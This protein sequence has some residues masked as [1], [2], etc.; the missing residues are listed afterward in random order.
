MKISL[1]H[2]PALAALLL[3]AVAH[4]NLI[5]NGGFEAP[6][7]Y[8]YGYQTMTSLPG[9]TV[10]PGGQV[11]VEGGGFWQAAEGNQSLDSVGNTGPGTYI[12]QSFSTTIGQS[13]DLTFDYANNPTG[14]YCTNNVLV[15]GATTLLN[16]VISHGGSANNNMNWVSFS[17]VFVADSSLTTLRFTHLGA[18]TD[19]LGSGIAL[20]AISVEAVPEPSVL[21]VFVIGMGAWLRKKAVK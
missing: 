1:F 4:G 21:T 8:F 5:S 16:S 10:S 2:I 13:Y 18:A 17:Q 19:P 7:V 20:D 9:W 12:Q 6:T 15:T 3:P 11:D 14:T